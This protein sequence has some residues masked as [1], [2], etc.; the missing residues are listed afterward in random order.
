MQ[1]LFTYILITI[2]SLSQAQILQIPLSFSKKQNEIQA[3]NSQRLRSLQQ[4]SA[5]LNLNVISDTNQSFYYGKIQLGNGKNN[6]FDVFFDTTSSFSWIPSSSCTSDSCQGFNKTYLCIYSDMCYQDNKQALSNYNYS[7]G[8]LYGQQII[9][10]LQISGL[11]SQNTQFYSANQI[12]NLENLPVDGVIGMQL[13]KSQNKSQESFLSIIQSEGKIKVPMFSLF[14]NQKEGSKITLGGFD[15]ASIMDQKKIYYHKVISKNQTDETFQWAVRGDELKIGS[16]SASLNATQKQI[17]ISSVDQFIGLNQD[18]FNDLM[19]YL[20]KQYKVF[21][22]QGYYFVDCKQIMPP[23]LI[24]LPDSNSTSR[25]YNLTSDYYINNTTQTCQ[26]MIKS[27]ENPDLNMILG[28]S[29][30]EKY[31]S[32]FTISN[33]TI[34]FAQSVQNQ[35]KHQSPLDQVLCII[36]VSICCSIL[37]III[38]VCFYKQCKINKSKLKNGVL[39]KEQHTDNKE[40]DQNTIKNP[41]FNTNQNQNHDSSFIICS[42][43]L[44]SENKKGQCVLEE[45]NDNHQDNL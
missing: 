7:G 35:Q 26:L 10:T 37:L 40:S 31:V 44:K 17:L 5:N 9:A 18:I 16:Y 24:A 28:T 13:L 2:L 27:L 12:L 29:F 6:S 22:N 15:P 30:L 36:I 45:N 4:D 43:N 32:I 33:S 34:G 38:G 3:L 1:Q 23:I 19:N 20:T 42:Q 8:Q 14:L 41:I 11:T 39:L 25:I 21:Q